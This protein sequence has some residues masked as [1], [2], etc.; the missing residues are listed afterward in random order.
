MMPILEE[1]GWKG[2]GEIKYNS[3]K[4]FLLFLII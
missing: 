2:L 3:W 4:N 1:I